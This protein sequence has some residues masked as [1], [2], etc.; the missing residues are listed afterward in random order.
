M[1]PTDDEVLQ[2]LAR[3]SADHG[4][5]AGILHAFS[6]ESL[7]EIW[8][9]EQREERSARYF[10][11]FLPALVVNGRV[12]VPNYDDGVNVYGLLP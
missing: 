7:K 3:R 2:A 5:V 10:V 12:Y 9:S 4:S 8:N 1:T 11:K 6:A